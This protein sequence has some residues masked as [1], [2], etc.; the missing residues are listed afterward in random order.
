MVELVTAGE[1]ENPIC[2][3]IVTFAQA[4][5]VLTISQRSFEKIVERGEIPT[6]TIGTRSRRVWLDDVIAYLKRNTAQSTPEV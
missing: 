6:I 2:A 5:E 3:Q 1:R 4:A